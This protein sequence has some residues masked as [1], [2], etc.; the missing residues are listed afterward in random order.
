MGI[1][2][3]F[4][5]AIRHEKRNL[6]NNPCEPHPKYNFG[7]CVDE[8]IMRNVGCQPPWRKFT[9]DELEYIAEIVGL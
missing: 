5:Q 7:Q 4:E 6:P 8:K 1:I 9:V 3:N 2:L